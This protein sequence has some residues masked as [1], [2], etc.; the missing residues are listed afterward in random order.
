MSRSQ[1]M[2]F[3]LNKDFERV[4]QVDD[5]ISFIWTQRFYAPGD[6]ELCCDIKYSQYIKKG[7]YVMRKNDQHAGIIEKINYKLT[8]DQQEMIIASGRMLPA[9]LARRI[10]SNQTQ[11]TG[12]V[13]ECIKLLVDENA[14]NPVNPARIIP[15]LTFT[16]NSQSTKEM[17][18]QYTGENLLETLA[19]ICET[20]SVGMDCI[21]DQ[22]NHFNFS[23]Y[24]GKDRSI[25]Q[26][27]YP[28]VVFAQSYENLLNSE[29]EADY[30]SYST[31]IL[32]GGEGEGI[33]RTFVWSSKDSQSG[34]DRYEKFLDA[35]TAV[36]NDQ[37]ITQ[38]TYE[39]QLEGLGLEELSEYT[40]A[41]SGEVDFTNVE[42]GKDI[43]VGDLCT[44]KN[45]RWGML[46]NTRLL[47]V[48]ESVG[49]DGAYTIL[50][51]FGE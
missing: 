32:V 45:E 11:L 16:T 22:N 43:D 31:D 4:A 29:Y 30:T 24:D 50:P 3:I 26:M 34:L 35:S 17:D 2:P 1:M 12:L 21:L 23:I 19:S 10:I 38:E 41:F 44:I 14:T 13:T 15:N 39:K 51:T 18:A 9:L 25:D 48:I 33:Y 46:V 5:Y 27:V 37:I 47:E 6:F 49:E 42:I 28:H 40:A 20:Y 36:S 8:D 7:G